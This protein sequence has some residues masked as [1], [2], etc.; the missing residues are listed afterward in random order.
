[1]MYGNGTMGLWGWI[2]MGLS[3][4]LFWGAVI[5]GIVLLA[6]ALG[7]GSAHAQGPGSQAALQP[8]TPAAPRPEDVLA[9]RFARGEIDE[10]EYR[11]RLDVLRQHRGGA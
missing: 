3:F 2:F 6:R 5:T 7:R 11:S 4:V 8:G 1:M 9:E 10:A